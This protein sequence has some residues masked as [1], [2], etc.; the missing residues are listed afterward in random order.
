M[1]GVSFSPVIFSRPQE[2]R[3][4]NGSNNDRGEMLALWTVFN[5]VEPNFT[6]KTLNGFTVYALLIYVGKAKLTA[7]F[8]PTEIRGA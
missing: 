6:T 7:R 3:Q 5:N 4:I 1:T 8:T 2:K